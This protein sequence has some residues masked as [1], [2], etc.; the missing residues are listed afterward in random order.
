MSNKLEAF[1]SQYDSTNR[2]TWR[3]KPDNLV[4]IA[5]IGGNYPTVWLYKQGKTAMIAVGC[6]RF[7]IENAFTHWQSLDNVYSAWRS[8][9]PETLEGSDSHWMRAQR[10]KVLG[11]KVLAKA[12]RKARNLGWN[13]G[14]Y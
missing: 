3:G 1:L 6:R 8:R 11:E 14:G 10:A 13:T 4:K 5:N 9:S 7:T 12:A 2:K